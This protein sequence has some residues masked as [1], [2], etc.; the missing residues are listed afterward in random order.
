[1]ETKPEPILQIP[2][3]LYSPPPGSAPQLYP[4]DPAFSHLIPTNLTPPHP[5]ARLPMTQLGSSTQSPN[6][7][8]PIPLP[9]KRLRSH[10]SIPHRLCLPHPVP[11]TLF[12]PTQL[13][14]PPR[15]IP[16]ALRREKIVM[17]VSLNPSTITEHSQQPHLQKLFVARTTR[18]PWM[19]CSKGQIH[20][21]SVWN[22]T[23]QHTSLDCVVLMLQYLV[24]SG[25]SASLKGD[26]QSN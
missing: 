14:P 12:P 13:P 15:T 3:S 26:E 4:T 24:S 21:M 6:L 10:W 18:E 9:S 19:S 20:F 1:M 2:R 11:P 7:A 17:N 16:S 22:S 8:P 23:R 5:Q 25:F